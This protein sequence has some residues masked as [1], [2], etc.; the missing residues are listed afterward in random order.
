MTVALSGTATEVG[1][2][3]VTIEVDHRS[4]GGDADVVRLTNYD[5]STALDGLS[6]GPGSRDLITASRGTVNL[7]GFSGPW[8]RDLADA[9]ERA[10]G[11]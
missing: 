3:G 1:D 2:D 10:F 11:S 9:F 5:A 6:F 7:R 4:A 8:S